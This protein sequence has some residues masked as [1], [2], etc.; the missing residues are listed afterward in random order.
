M[1]IVVDRVVGG[2]IRIDDVGD[3]FVRL[4]DEEG[5]LLDIPMSARLGAK[6]A[7]RAQE[8]GERGSLFDGEN[9]RAVVASL[10][11][12]ELQGI[13]DAFAQQVS[14]I[15]AH[16][17]LTRR[18]PREVARAIRRLVADVGVQRSLMMADWLVT[19][20][21]AA[22]TLAGLQA[23]GVTHV[24]TVPEGMERGSAWPA[25]P[26]APASASGEQIED[27]ARKRPQHRHPR[28]GQFVTKAVAT[29]EHGREKSGRF[30]KAPPVW[31]RRTMKQRERLEAAFEESEADVL[32]AG[33]DKVCA[34]CQDI[35]DDGPYTIAEAMDLVPVH[36]NCRCLF[37]PAG[38]VEK[39]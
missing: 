39:D 5:A 3:V 36:V 15:V 28:S 26:S 18:R 27:A 17:L 13:C 22:S 11:Q 20:A 37:V 31:R 19:K 1:T 14:R 8:A 32:T 4:S 6:L 21:H 9:E 23:A 10:A 16:A 12:S 29:R 25:G 33:D 30:G 24:G 2:N 38:D 35:S 34:K 7:R